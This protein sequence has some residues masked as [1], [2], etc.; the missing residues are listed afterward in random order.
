MSAGDGRF[1]PFDPNDNVL[2]APAIGAIRRSRPA[3][4]RDLG[5]LSGWRAPPAGESIPHI[6]PAGVR[7]HPFRFHRPKAQV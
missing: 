3:R 4:F 7:A 2:D 1:S 6:N 5:T